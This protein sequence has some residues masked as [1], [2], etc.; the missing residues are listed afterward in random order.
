MSLHDQISDTTV[1]NECVARGRKKSNQ[2]DNFEMTNKV[3][4]CAKLLD[5]LR[6]ELKGD[7]NKLGNSEVFPN[8]A[9][10]KSLVKHIIRISSESVDFPATV[11]FI[12]EAVL[13][14]LQKSKED[15]KGNALKSHLYQWKKLSHEHMVPCEAVLVELCKQTSEISEVLNM[16]SFRA[17]VTG[18]NRKGQLNEVRTLDKDYSSELPL[19]INFD[20]KGKIA[21]TN[22][23]MRFFPLLRYEAVG[24]INELIPISNRAKTLLNDY[25]NFKDEL[26]ENA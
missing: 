6:S 26:P 21:R 3:A 20:K 9:E 12:T 11:D 7:W 13:E 22:I 19:T 15:N 16:L 24:L 2:P 8:R 1:Y 4:F 17:L 10:T 23:D 18:P 14:I 5:V 25:K